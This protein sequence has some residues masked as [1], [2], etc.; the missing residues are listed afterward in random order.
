MREGTVLIDAARVRLRR[1]ELGLTQEELAAKSGSSKR[2]IE[3]VEAGKAVTLRTANEIAEALGLSVKEILVNR[4]AADVP[5]ARIVESDRPPSGNAPA[6]PSLLIGRERDLDELTARLCRQV[7]GEEPKTTQVVT[8]VRGW[9]GVGK[10]T[11]ARAIAHWPPIA[12][13]FPDG[14]LWVALGLTPQILP[15]L[16]AWGR[17]LGDDRILLCNDV[18]EASQ[19]IGGLLRDR[20][21]LLIVDDAW[22]ASHVLPFA[23]GGRHCAMLVTTRAS[24]VADS[25]AATPADVYYLDILSE[26]QSM[27][28]LGALA[29]K[30]VEAYR[31]ECL[32]LVAMLEGLPLALQVAGRLLRNEHAKGWSVPDLLAELRH[33]VARLLGTQAPSDTAANPGDVSPTVAALLHKSTDCL[34]PS[35]RERFAFLA[36]FAPRPATFELEDMMAVWQIDESS[37]RE[38]IDVLAD[39]GLLEPIGNGEFQIHQVLV[40]HAKTLLKTR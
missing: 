16:L 24:I 15:G 40:Q 22:D 21:M 14:V 10:T 18:S 36:P 33:D 20:R 27:E 35:I 25:L 4:S 9:P 2:T 7:A 32:E 11:V 13:G 26:R 19:R 39:R 38:T 5:G 31:A 28:L 37:A 8:A 6:L 29:P 34:E 3:N 1:Q 12:D 23:V 17:S 30:I